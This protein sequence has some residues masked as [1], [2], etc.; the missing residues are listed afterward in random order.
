MTKTELDPKSQPIFCLKCNN[1]LKQLV[2]MDEIAFEISTK[3]IFFTFIQLIYERCVGYGKN[4]ISGASKMVGIC[5]TVMMFGKVFLASVSNKN[6]ARCILTA[7]IKKIR[8]NF[9]L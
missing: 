3:A 9:H 4:S 5:G 8:L 7:K 2:S 1:R 6:S